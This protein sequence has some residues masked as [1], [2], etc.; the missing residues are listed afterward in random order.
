M[1]RLTDAELDRLDAWGKRAHSAR[2]WDVAGLIAEVR[3]HRAAETERSM[4]RLVTER[5]GATHPVVR[6]D[7]VAAAARRAAARA[8]HARPRRA[9]RALEDSREPEEATMTHA[10]I[11]PRASEAEA[12]EGRPMTRNHKPRGRR[13]PEVADDASSLRR[14]PAD[15]PL[16]GKFFHSFNRTADGK[17]ERI[18]W[19][20]VVEAA[21]TETL[22]LVSTFSWL[23]GGRT[24]AM[25]LV[26]LAEMN[27][28]FFYADGETMAD[29]YE[30]GDARHYR[31]DAK[32]PP[33]DE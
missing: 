20:G 2:G 12:E 32:E 17:R 21:V 22:Y 9:D 15:C 26:P 24:W 1:T 27:D 14:R 25:H 18:M 28:W 10:K 8:R 5:T 30:H 3:E 29:S 11:T 13:K 33:F 31:Y 7:A 4:D 19:Q 23:T 6:L 16:V